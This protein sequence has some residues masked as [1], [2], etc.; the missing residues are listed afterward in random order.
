[1]T[2][3][4]VGPRCAALVGPGASGKTT[5]LE[6]LLFAAGAI[7]RR[8]SVKEGSTVGDAAPRPAPAS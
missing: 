5:L 6:E 8:G 4:P 7:E 1:M 3:H 2:H